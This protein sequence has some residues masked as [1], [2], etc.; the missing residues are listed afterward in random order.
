MVE[1]EHEP[2]IFD[3]DPLSDAFQSDIDINSELLDVDNDPIPEMDDAEF[4]QPSP[5]MHKDNPHV[6]SDNAVEDDEGIDIPLPDEISED[7]EEDKGGKR[8]K[9]GKT[10]TKGNKNT[11]VK[12]TYEP[13]PGVKLPTIPEGIATRGEWNIT[14]Y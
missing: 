4:S 3:D 11:G 14:T 13:P 7:E 10:D 12:M 5:L 1:G 8:H 2:Q 6:L 9:G